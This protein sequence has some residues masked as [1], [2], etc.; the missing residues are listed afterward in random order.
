M[1]HLLFSAGF[2]FTSVVVY[3]QN[4]GIGTNTP[5]AKL[6]VNG[7]IKLQNGVA[8]SGI[9][10]DS[11]FSNASHLN[12]PTQ[13]AVKDFLQRGQW[14]AIDSTTPG[15]NAPAYLN[16]GVMSGPGANGIA[17]N[18]NYAYTISSTINQL[19]VFDISDPMAILMKGS[20][21]T[22]LDFPTSIAVSG[23]YVYVT[24]AYN[25]SLSI[26]DV[27]NP[28]SIVPRGTTTAQLQFPRCVV[29]RGIYAYVSNEFTGK[30]NIYDI[31]NPD[32]IVLKASGGVGLGGIINLDVEGNYA[33]VTSSS[34]SELQIYDISNP[35]QVVYKSFTNFGLNGPRSVDVVGNYAFVVSYDGSRLS[36]FDISNP[37]SIQ[38]KANSA[39]GLS[40][41]S[42]VKVSGKYVFI[43]SKTSSRLC[44]Y[45]FTAPDGLKFIGSNNGVLATPEQVVLKGNQAYVVSSASSRAINV[46]DLDLKRTLQYNGTNLESQ[47]LQWQTLENSIYRVN[48][49]VGIGT[50][51]PQAA[52]D[53]FGNI[54]GSGYLSVPQL[55]STTLN[56]NSASIPSVSTTDISFSNDLG[57][58]MT[59]YNGGATRYGIGL[60]S[61]LMQYYTDLSISDHVFGFGSSTSF[62]EKF[63]IKG[64]GNVGIGISNPSRPL[65][66]PATLEKKISFYPGATGDVGI[67]VSGNDLRL[68][69]DNVNARVSF[70]YDDYNAGFISRAYVLASGGT[71]MVVQGQLNVNGTIYNSDLRFKKNIFTIQNAI[72]KVLALRGVNYEMQTEN[73]P[74]RNFS[75]GTQMGLIAQEVEQVVPEVVNTAAD[76]YKSVDYAKL[77]PLL[78]EGIKAQQTTLAEQ[79]RKLD[80]QQKEID[81]LKQDLKRLL[82]HQ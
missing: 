8:V 21:Y 52:L 82:K 6:H 9:S 23:N 75:A 47:P 28:N 42:S 70:G 5:Q 17:I 34:S 19:Q 64:N 60:Q 48:G 45:E 62:T 68:Y 66:F 33:Y 49:R 36:V 54:L 74:D 43:S 41:P 25:N 39:I 59:I 37:L 79:Q 58:K 67:S 16:F 24:N 14:A 20:T 61:G 4:T 46:F 18:G 55:I 69:S 3:S 72:E 81:Q 50:S 31:S 56:S 29:V 51:V 32:A 44:L 65:S 10:N 13:K 78:I 27:S 11:S 77:V 35:N 26:F 63:R 71:A 30:I 7:D 15:P 1:R 73:F 12:I 38:Y 76:G 22:N 53:V 57:N 2:L 80:A 40:G